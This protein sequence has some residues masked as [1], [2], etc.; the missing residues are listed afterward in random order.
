MLP[1]VVACKNQKV[2]DSKSISTNELPA[3]TNHAV[4]TSFENS[5]H[6]SNVSQKPS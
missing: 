1:E 5:I 4:T 6:E 2:I 3:I